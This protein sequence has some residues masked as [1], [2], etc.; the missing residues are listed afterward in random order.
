MKKLLLFILIFIFLINPACASEECIFFVRGI[1]DIEPA[2]DILQLLYDASNDA[3]YIA[4][5][6]ANEDLTIED[7]V[8]Y[9]E[10][11]THTDTLIVSAFQDAGITAN[12]VQELLYETDIFKNIDFITD[13]TEDITYS[14]NDSISGVNIIDDVTIDAAVI[15]TIN[16]LNTVIIAD[17][18][19]NDGSVDVTPLGG[20]G[21]NA[22]GSGDG[23]IGGGN[24]LIL[25]NTFNNSGTI[26]ANGENGE[27]GTTKDSGFSV[28]SNGSVGS[29]TRIGDSIIGYG[30]RGGYDIECEENNGGF[31]AGGGSTT[32]Y[33]FPSSEIKVSGGDGGAVNYT[34]YDTSTDFVNQQKEAMVDY[35]LENVLFKIPDATE[36]FIIGYGGGGGGGASS[37]NRGDCGGGAG[38]G[39]EIDCITN[40]F[41]NT[42][43]IQANGA[44]GGDKGSEGNFDTG[45][46]GGGGGA[47][48]GLYTNLVNAGTVQ[49]LGGTKGTTDSPGCEPAVDGTAGIASHGVF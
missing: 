1:Y 47:V 29:I 40:S 18:F 48:K 17:T 36:D 6:L 38:S 30:G 24:L 42:G 22:D 12:R 34:T 8:T 16:A 13:G 26:Q 10:S 11:E 41:N 19:G 9:L 35:W 3:S 4:G 7:G 5:L 49:A 43:T 46:G 14:G 27:D 15:L 45:G 31:G 25:S 39:G 20:N 28:G 2:E 23:G 44:N 37:A 21:G 32:R 33:F